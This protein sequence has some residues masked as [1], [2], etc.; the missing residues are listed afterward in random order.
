MPQGT[1]D[2]AAGQMRTDSSYAAVDDSIEGA[3]FP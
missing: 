1:F 3:G 2:T